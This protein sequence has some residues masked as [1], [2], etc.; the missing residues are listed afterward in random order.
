MHALLNNNQ[1]QDFGNL[2]APGFNKITDD[3][4]FGAGINYTIAYAFHS[5]LKKK[6]LKLNRFFTKR[7]LHK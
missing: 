1:P 7:E 4:K 3:N 6:K 2:H 5:G